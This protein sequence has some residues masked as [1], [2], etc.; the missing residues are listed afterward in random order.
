MGADMHRSEVFWEFAFYGM[1][2]TILILSLLADW[3]TQ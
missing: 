3:T 2:A 1:L